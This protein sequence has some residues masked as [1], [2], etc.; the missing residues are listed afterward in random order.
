MFTAYKFLYSVTTAV[1]KNVRVG[2][3]ICYRTLWEKG[4][5]MLHFI[6]KNCLYTYV[7]VV[8]IFYVRLTSTT[9]GDLKSQSIF[10]QI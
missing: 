1:P 2:G 10:S 8:A 9:C 6:K 5:K 4:D 7:P 3:V